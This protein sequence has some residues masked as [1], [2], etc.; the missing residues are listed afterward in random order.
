ML[1]GDCTV[2]GH[3]R[4]DVV[5]GDV[6]LARLRKSFG[7]WPA[8]IAQVLAAADESSTFRHAIYDRPCRRNRRGR[9][10]VVLVG[11]AAHP[12]TPDLGQG[13][14]QAIEDA[15][16]LVHCLTIAPDQVAALRAFEELRW[17]RVRWIVRRARL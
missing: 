17:P 10:R 1:S 8:P 12:M 3:C 6:D 15:E 16:V 7:T 2:R 11:D 13:A 4:P 9:G 5:P 14:C